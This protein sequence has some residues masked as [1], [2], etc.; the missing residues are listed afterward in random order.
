MKPR[1][2]VAVVLVVLWGLAVFGQA[3]TR[4]NPST[5][6]E[7][8]RA[9]ELTRKLEKQP[10]GPTAAEERAWLTQ[11]IIEIPDLTVPICD[12]VLR[13]VLQGGMGQYRY[14][15]ELV[16]QSLAGSM[17]FLIEHPQPAD[18]AEQ[19]DFAIN[20]A[21]LNSALNAYESIV[22]SG[23]KGGKWAPLEELL[24]KRKT[25]ELDDY[26]RQSTVRC[27]T[28]DTIRAALQR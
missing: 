21:G 11:W 5:P 23:A 27:M 8:K 25:G 19:D 3:A 2:L 20:K 22:K 7:R 6:E 14:S 28:G 26:I 13:P 1:T 10:L 18:P 24:R 17:V 9:V 16:A 12:E 15:K 4:E